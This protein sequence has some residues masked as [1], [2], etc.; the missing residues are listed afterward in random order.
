MVSSLA[1]Q[2]LTARVTGNMNSFFVYN[3]EDSGFNHGFPSGVFP[4]GASLLIDAGCL[5][6]PTDK[7]TGCY[8][9]TDTTHLDTTRGTVL[10]ITFP[11]LSSV[12]FAGL[13]IEEPQNWGLLITSKQCGVAV[14]CN[15]YNLTGS[16][17]VQFDDVLLPGSTYSLA[18]ASAKLSFLRCPPLKLIRTCLCH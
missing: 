6:N 15:G 4:S 7:T 14:T 18:S 1:Y 17:T 5:D 12:S 2:T 8:P 10:R 16:T 9:S 13:N 11:S 3:D